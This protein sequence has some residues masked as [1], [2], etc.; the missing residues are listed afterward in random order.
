MSII[1]EDKFIDTNFDEFCKLDFLE[2]NLA[3]LAV[4]SLSVNTGRHLAHDYA[5][6]KKMSKGL[7]LAVSLVMRDFIK[8]NFKNQ[9]RVGIA[10]P[11]G[12]PGMI[13]NLATQLA[14]KSCVNLNFTLGRQSAQACLDIAKIEGIVSAT[15]LREKLPERGID[16]PWT[17]KFFDVET[18]IKNLSKAKI[19]RNLL[20]IKTLPTKALIKLF[21]VPTAGG[22]NEASIIFTSGSEGMPKA[23]VLSHKNIVGNCLQMHYVNFIEEDTILHANLP[24]FH[25]FGQSIQLWFSLLFGT[26]TVMVPSPLDVRQ[27]FDAIKKGKST[28]M[29]STP[30]FLRSYCRKGNPDSIASLKYVIAGAEKT[31]EG[32]AQM[33]EER[34]PNC[35]YKEGYGLTEASPVVSV[36]LFPSSKRNKFRDYESKTKFGSIGPLFPGMKAGVMDLDTKEF[37]PIGSTGM[38]C[39]KGPNVFK[40]Y[41]D[42][43]ELNAERFHDDWL[44]TG[45][46]AYI[47]K[48]GFTFIKGRLSRFSKIGGEMVPH[49]TIEEAIIKIYEREN[50]EELSIAVGSRDDAAKGE[51]IVLIT[52]LDIDKHDLRKRL[53]DAGFANLWIPRYVV[54]CDKIPVLSTGKMD[55]K[56]VQTM[57]KTASV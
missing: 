4:K 36:N 13:V 54:K 14:G 9:E 31:P 50:D 39:L 22:E 53:S 1:K 20:L 3:E 10:L 49:T 25:S 42:M 27:N 18:I 24:L 48:D 7:V 23:A 8:E 17:D 33:W 2:G 38:Y 57:A 47:D 35:K 29:I 30:T 19:I 43:P 55:I 11:S 41:L 32:F 6:Q 34:F 37:L 51:C 40:G 21:S 56:A 45:D 44:V 5:L 46:I 52:T 12:I 28:V 16:F 15:K 26:P